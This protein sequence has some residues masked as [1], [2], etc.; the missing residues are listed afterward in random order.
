MRAPRCDQRKREHPALAHQLTAS[1]RIVLAHLPWRVG[2]VELDRSAAAGLEVDEQRAMLR[3]QQVARVRLAV[4]E[5]L[6]GAPVE[7][8]ARHV[9]QRGDEQVA[10]L[11]REVE[12]E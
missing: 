4:E 6:R 7:D 10:V 12:T 9:A 3:R 2:N 8:G 5:L 11:V 1:A